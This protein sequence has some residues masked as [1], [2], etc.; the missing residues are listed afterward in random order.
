MTEIFD[1]AGAYTELQNFI[2][3]ESHEDVIKISDIILKNSPTEKEALQCKLV[4]LVHL[5]KYDEGIELCKVNKLENE[6][7]LEYSYCLHEKKMYKET[8][9]FLN[10]NK[11]NTPQLNL[12]K[13]QSFY[14]LGDY[15][16]CFDILKREAETGL[17][18]DLIANYLAGY[19]LSG[20]QSDITYIIKQMTSWEGYFNYCLIQLNKGKFGDSMETLV[21]MENMNE[22]DDYNKMKVKNLKFSLIQSI[23]EGFDFLKCTSLQEEYSGLLKKNSFKNMQ[24]YFYN[25]FLH[26]KKEKENLN[27]TLKKLENY[28]KN[29]SLTIDEKFV[30]HINKIILL[31]RSNKFVEAQKEFKV[32]EEN[33][34]NFHSDIRFILVK[35]YI[36]AKCDKV[37]ALEKVCEEQYK[38]IPEVQLILIQQLLSNLTTKTQEEF[39]SKLMIFVN[40]FKS[41]S[42]N[43]AFIDFFIKFY[44]SRHLKSYLKDFISLFKNSE[45]IKKYVDKSNAKNIYYLLGFSLYKCYF[46]KEAQSFYKLILDEID[47]YDI[48]AKLWYANCLSHFDNKQTEII[49]KELDDLTIDTSEQYISSL[50]NDVFTRSKKEKGV[51]NDQI[52]K[53]K[54]RKNKKK[55]LPKNFDSK[56]PMPDAERW[57]PRMQRKK[58]KNATK[59]KKNY[60][61]ATTDNSTTVNTFKK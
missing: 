53:K 48:E 23:F 41:Y 19:L 24:P 51:K 44:E 46:F 6:F 58:Y 39:H 33:N 36:I 9:E 57:V 21:Q 15:K 55:I 52:E 28:A 4:A 8:I 29:E 49:R 60:Q 54:K 32:I 40:N 42:V 1:I 12:C 3:K 56:T 11:K 14:K 20:D 16:S 31:L 18:D 35:C 5:N 2:T 25:N 59:N 45:E 26:S 61:G 13:A 43:F 27:E 17:N 38:N 22:N 10:T 47:E 7:S 50:I 37:E 34:L 30:I